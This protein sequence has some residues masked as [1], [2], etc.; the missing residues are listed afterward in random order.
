MF[1]SLCGIYKPIGCLIDPLQRMHCKK[2]LFLT[3][4]RVRLRDRNCFITIACQNHAT[5]HEVERTNIFYRGMNLVRMVK[6]MHYE[7]IDAPI[8]LNE[9]S[10]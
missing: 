10:L 8:K 9:A 6:N 4:P 2:R 3:Q 1:I 7:S 5:F